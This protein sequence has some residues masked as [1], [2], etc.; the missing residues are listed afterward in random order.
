MNSTLSLL[1]KCSTSTKPGH[2]LPADYVGYPGLE[3]VLNF[4]QES[5]VT[6]AELTAEDISMLLNRLVFDGLVE[7]VVS[8]A[9]VP[10]RIV[11]DDED[12]NIYVYKA[13][14][15]SISQSMIGSLPCGT[16]PI[17]DQCCDFGPVTPSTCQYYTEWLSY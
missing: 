10:S 8:M 5:K 15:S 11:S 9:S 17:F 13:V 7:K 16:C 14:Q 2:I 6:S 3:Q 1:K 12:D 4:V